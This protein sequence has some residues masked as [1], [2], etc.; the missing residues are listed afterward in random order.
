MRQKRT[1]RRPPTIPT[2]ASDRRGACSGARRTLRALALDRS[3]TAGHW[4]LVGQRGLVTSIRSSGPEQVA[5][6]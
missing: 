5:R 4:H 3:V 1:S 6:R 2:L